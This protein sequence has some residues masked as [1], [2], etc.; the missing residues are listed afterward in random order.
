MTRRHLA[1][2]SAVV[3]TAAL[4]ALLLSHVEM[5][6]LVATLKSIEPGYVLLGLGAYASCYLFRALRFYVLL[7]REVRVADLFAI[8]CVHNMVNDIL[9]AR[10]GELSY[11]YLLKKLHHKNAR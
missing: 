2:A 6:D 5:S 1:R 4:L 10:S 11:I 3:V 9:P 7:N 8:V